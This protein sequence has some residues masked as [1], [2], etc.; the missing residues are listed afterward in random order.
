M[1][2]AVAT[3]RRGALE[4][5]AAGEAAVAGSAIYAGTVFHR[6]D[7]PVRHGFRYRIFMPL[8]DLDQLP[9][10][11]DRIPLWSA[12]RPAP[13]RLRRSD[14]L[15]PPTRP[16]ATAA[17][18]LVAERTGR[19]PAGPVRLLANPRYW[20]VGFNPVA[21]YYL[22]GPGPEGGVEAI[23]AEVTN[24]PWGERRAYVLEPGP[25]G[26]EGSFS[27]R[28]HVSPFMPMEQEYRW[29]AEA[30]G[31]RLR[32]TL[33][34]FQADRRV[35]EAG[36]DLRRREISP[37]LMLRLLAAYPP[38][39]VAALARIYWNAAK[40]KAKGAPYFPHPGARRS[41]ET[42]APDHP[43]AARADRERADRA[44]R[45]VPGRPDQGLRPHRLDPSGPTG[46]PRS[47]GLRP[48]AALEER[49]PGDHLRGGPLG[50]R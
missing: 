25:A 44:G 19:R 21:F 34:N 18:D 42:S 20:G 4:R 47:L 39:T 14:F 46:D 45:D 49:R 16:L 33:A 5:P 32:L 35:F 17:R 24:T 43:H 8:F 50:R 27:K 48:A 7:E 23:I 41:D 3:P 40:L 9:E 38:M 37:R 28:L 15:G 11:L 22:F 2:A 36:I 26:L 29:R 13:A 30:P 6:R 1:E 12:R 31:D 10:L